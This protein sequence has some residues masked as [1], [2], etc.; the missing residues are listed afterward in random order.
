MATQEFIETGSTE[1]QRAY[2]AEQTTPKTG[3]IE[4][5]SDRFAGNF[6][7]QNPEVQEMLQP[8]S[9]GLDLSDFS[10]AELVELSS[11]INNTEAGIDV[12]TAERMGRAIQEL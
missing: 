2:R 3:S 11:Y 7:A 9:Q 1:N 6:L 4:D 5:A 8:V 10:Q 12:G